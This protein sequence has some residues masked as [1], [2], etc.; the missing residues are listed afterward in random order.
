MRRTFATTLLLATLAVISIPRIVAA[1]LPAREEGDAG[2]NADDG[3]SVTVVPFDSSNDLIVV[4]ATLDGKG[5]FRFV[6]DTGASRHAITPQVARE[7]GLKVEGG[8]RID[9]GLKTTASAGVA[10]VARVEIGGCTLADQ[11]FFVAPMPA[12]F[13]F[14]GFLGA[15][16]FRRFAI[17]VNFRR[18]QLTLTPASAFNYKGGG[19]IV[20]L[21]FYRRSTP[22]VRAALD[23]DSGWFK[24]DTGY[25][26]AL[27]LF[28]KFVVAHKLTAKYAPH[29]SAAGGT[30]IAG[31]VGDVSIARVPLLKIGAIELR[32]TE[33][34]LYRDAGTSNDA[35]A[36]AI[37]TKI[38]ERFNVI[39]DYGG[40]RLILEKPT[41]I[42]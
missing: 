4:N 28:A 41:E 11:L 39:F 25:N 36:G 29:A 37:G 24:I 8:A 42:K 20:P 22:M 26:G 27:A 17:V 5:P 30:T 6:L 32:D 34:A 21:K 18:N 12:S 2:V 35:F 38:F 15:E 3:S 13:P 14:Q 1:P 9:A 7:L 16:V 19:A 10:R 33:A 31:E 40:G 23:G